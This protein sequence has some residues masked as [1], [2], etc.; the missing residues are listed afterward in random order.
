[1][2]LCIVCLERPVGPTADRLLC[3]TC[4]ETVNEAAFTRAQGG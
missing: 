3:P 2:R 4:R 1:M